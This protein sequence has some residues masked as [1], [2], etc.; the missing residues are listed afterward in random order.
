MFLIHWDG[1]DIRLSDRCP[2]GNAL[3]VADPQRT[4]RIIEKHGI[5]VLRN[6]DV[7]RMRAGFVA[8][9]EI[10]MLLVFTECG[11]IRTPK[12]VGYNHVP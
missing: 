4:G 2:I 10:V 12:Y 3:F 9:E 5:I 1:A 7:T 6:P 8:A 11:G